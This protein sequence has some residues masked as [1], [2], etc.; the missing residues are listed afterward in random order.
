MTKRAWSVTVTSGR[1]KLSTEPSHEPIIFGQFIQSLPRRPENVKPLFKGQLSAIPGSG[2]YHNFREASRVWSDVGRSFPEVGMRSLGFFWEGRAR[3]CGRRSWP[4]R[5]MILPT[6]S[7]KVVRSAW[8]LTR[9][10][11]VVHR[12]EKSVYK[13]VG[14]GNWSGVSFPE[15]GPAQTALRPCRRFAQAFLRCRPGQ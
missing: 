13:A 3:R 6:T 11:K 5:K 2:S 15:D 1:H 9:S 10:D 14:I 8:S 4:S 7:G 12:F